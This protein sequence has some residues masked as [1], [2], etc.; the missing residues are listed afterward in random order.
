[1]PCRETSSAGDG[2]YKTRL[3]LSPLLSPSHWPLLILGPSAPLGQVTAPP[4]HEA[5]IKAPSSTHRLWH[6]LWTLGWHTLVLSRLDG[7]GNMQAGGEPGVRALP[8]ECVAAGTLSL[9]GSPCK[10]QALGAEVC[11]V[12]Q[13]RGLLKAVLQTMYLH[14]G[15]ALSFSP[16]RSLS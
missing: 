12:P 3:W 1:M 7:A 14:P 9:S 6:G 5:R 8:S 4:H 2:C 16:N 10:C 11:S 13:R 15:T